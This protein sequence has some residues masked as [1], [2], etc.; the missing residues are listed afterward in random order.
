MASRHAHHPLARVVRITSCATAVVL[1]LLLL[2]VASATAISWRTSADASWALGCDFARND[3]GSARVRGEDCSGRCGATS[4][5]SH[6]AWTLHN[7]GTCWLKGG[8]RPALSK[9]VASS[10]AGAM[11]G[12][13]RSVSNGGG[14]RSC[15]AT[16]EVGLEVFCSQSWR[17]VDVARLR[18]D[19]Q[20]A[21]INNMKCRGGRS[22]YDVLLP[23]RSAPLGGVIT[24]HVEVADKIAA[25]IGGWTLRD[26]RLVTFR[27]NLP[28]TSGKRSQALCFRYGTKNADTESFSEPRTCM[29]CMVARKKPWCVAANG[30]AGTSDILSYKVWVIQTTSCR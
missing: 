23:S 20:L 22:L 27:F 24:T 3:I 6:F 25:F 19:G 17:N 13:L 7:G 26:K 1:A 9:A 4:G 5:C 30:K 15:K 16:Y 28:S 11:C 21:T 18:V 12:V 29:S 14:G 10:K 8:P 2:L